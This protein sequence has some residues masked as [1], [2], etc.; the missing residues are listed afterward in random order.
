MSEEDFWQLAYLVAMIADIPRPR[1]AADKAMQ[2]YLD[3]MNDDLGV[4]TDL[5]TH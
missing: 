5:N 1:E 4:D 3:F 2:D